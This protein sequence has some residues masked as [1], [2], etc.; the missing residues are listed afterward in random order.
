ML[1]GR[2]REAAAPEAESMLEKLGLGKR[3]FALPREM[4]GGEQR[5][6]TLARVF[7][8]K[9]RIVVGIGG[10]AERRARVAL[11]GVNVAVG[12]I[13]HP[14]PASPLANRGWAVAIERQLQELGIS[15]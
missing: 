3:L 10:F 4:S 5:R 12:T 8:L 7:A 13:L 11:A 14:S 15:L 9:P 6:V 2:T 1:G